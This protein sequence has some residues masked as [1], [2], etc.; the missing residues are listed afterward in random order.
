MGGLLPLCIPSKIASCAHFNVSYFKERQFSMVQVAH[1]I[2]H[3]HAWLI[4]WSEEV[5]SILTPLIP[6]VWPWQTGSTVWEF[7]FRQSINSP[8]ASLSL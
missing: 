3:R 2:I 7:F 4:A 6:F 8:V 1:A 5:P